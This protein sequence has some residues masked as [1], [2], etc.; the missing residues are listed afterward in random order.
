MPSPIRP[1]KMTPG[2][3]FREIATILAEGVLRARKRREPAA[4]PSSEKVLES[5]AQ[6]LEVPRDTRLSVLTG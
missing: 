3:R 4:G 5:A 1:D 6:G 2:D